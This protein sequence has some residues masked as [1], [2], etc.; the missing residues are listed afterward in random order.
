M[1]ASTPASA[2]TTIRPVSRKIAAGWPSGWECRPCI[3][4]ACIRPIR[5]TSWWRRDHGRARTRPRADA[6]VTRTEGLA[7]GASAADCG[8]ILLVDPNARVIGAAHAGW[9]GA[10]TGIAGIHR[11]GDGKTRRRTQR[12]RRRHRAPDPPAL[13]RSRRR[14]RR[15]LHRGRY[16]ERALFH[17]LATRGPRD[18]RSRRLHPDAARKRRRA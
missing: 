6:I 4:S 2:R 18:V 14:I 13:L 15:A 12:H 5:P 10:L 8:P 16:R 3:F 17:S 1:P 11:R 9:K 7:I